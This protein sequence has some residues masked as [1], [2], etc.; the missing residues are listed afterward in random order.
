MGNP[1]RWVEL[2]TDDLDAG[3]RVLQRDI[4]LEAGGI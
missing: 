1:F 3:Q 4:Q 2:T